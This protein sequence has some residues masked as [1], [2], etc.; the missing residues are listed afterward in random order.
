M[1]LSDTFSSTFTLKSKFDDS[2][3]SYQPNM[4]DIKDY[5]NDRGSASRII[6]ELKSIIRENK[7]NDLGL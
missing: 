1:D 2:K 4:I 6:S 3:Y 7:L 5:P